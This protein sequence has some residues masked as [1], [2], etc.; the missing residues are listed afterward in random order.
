MN[1]YL[2]LVIANLASYFR[3]LSSILSLLLQKIGANAHLRPLNEFKLVFLLQNVRTHLTYVEHLIIIDVQL[4]PD[5]WRRNSQSLGTAL[6]HA[7]DLPI[8]I[9]KQE[10]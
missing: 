8:S 3:E 6:R 4:L 2:C 9:C 7:M 10:T 5:G 1:A